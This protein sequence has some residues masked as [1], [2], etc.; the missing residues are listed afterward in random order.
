[1]EEINFFK[2]KFIAK[3]DDQ[4]YHNVYV[5]VPDGTPE[6]YIWILAIRECGKFEHNLQQLSFVEEVTTSY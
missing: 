2:C 3:L 4:T 5:K 1:M 6:D